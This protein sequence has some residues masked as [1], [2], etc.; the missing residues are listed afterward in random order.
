MEIDSLLKNWQN[1][2]SITENIQEW[3]TIPAREAILNP[4]PSELHPALQKGLQNL[5][6]HFLYSHQSQAWECAH[7]G[8][9]IAIVTGTASGKTLGYSLPV[10]HSLL[11]QKTSRALYIFPTKA[12]AQDQLEKIKNMVAVSQLDNSKF[13]VAIYDGDTPASARSTIRTQSRLLLTNPDMLHIGILPHHTRWAHFFADLQFIVIDEMHTYRG[14]FGS[15]VANVIRRL[16]RIA[17]FY[18]AQPQFILTSATIANPQELAQRLTGENVQIIDQ[19]GAGRGDRHFVIYNPPVIDQTTGIRRSIIQESI[20]LADDLLAYKIQSIIFGRSRRTVELILTYFRQRVTDSPIN[21]TIRG[22]R[23]GYL[24]HERREIEK[25]LRTGQVQTVIATTALELGVDIGGMGAVILAGY[26]GTIAATWQQA[27]RAGR[28]L[29][30]SLAVLITSAAPLDQFL[31]KHP[32][33]LFERSPE[34]ALIDP[35]NLLILLDHLR[36]AAFELP[37]QPEEHYGGLDF[38]QTQELLNLLCTQGLLH[39]SGEKFFWMADQYPAQNISLR[40]VS[41]RPITLQV[42]DENGPRVIGLIDR[43][44]AW[45]FVHPQ[46]V[47]LHDAQTFEVEGLDLEND[48]ARLKLVETDFYTEPRSDTLAELIAETK[49]ETTPAGFKA[50]GE[51][52]VT[53]LLKGYRRVKWHTHE[54]LGFGEASLPPEELTTTGYWI[55]LNQETIQKLQQQGLWN[56]SANQYGP[57]WSVQRDRV[58]A[59]D[60]YRCQVCGVSERDKQHHVH[61]KIPFKLFESFLD[62]NQLDNL[63]TLCPT[64]HQRVELA[65]RVRSGL[66]GLAYVLGHL[67]PFFL[68]CD[69]GDLGVT[70]DPQSPIADGLACVILYDQIPAGIGLSQHLF[71]IHPEL[72][73]KAHELVRDCACVDGCPS[74]VGPGG[75][76][77]LGGKKETLAILSALIDDNQAINSDR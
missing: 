19:D 27:G 29:E 20:R 26:P 46:A 9:N 75:E 62:A 58:R 43:A 74:C 12:L 16:K 39:R 56:S 65:V 25:G 1:E 31:A 42:W 38:D 49:R 70:A 22:D 32:E 51:I 4:L 40:S 52:K 53:T 55:A 63:M 59:R 64:C 11:T 60:G 30:T 57:N 66:S 2:K 17:H 41:V 13:Q 67:A 14:V 34:Y 54:T 8:Q 3:R 10:F 68:M 23:S 61:H 6:I 77:G 72:I 69:R 48:L 71:E 28:G 44:S 35:D 15:H 18:G 47:Y 21:Q 37:F 50:H 76:N 45:R 73:Q 33:Y 7:L 5:G 36:C 24:P